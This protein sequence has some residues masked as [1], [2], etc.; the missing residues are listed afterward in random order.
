MADAAFAEDIAGSFCT[1]SGCSAAL[2]SSD[3]VASY[4]DCFGPSLHFEAD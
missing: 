1:K 3:L 4:L 2:A